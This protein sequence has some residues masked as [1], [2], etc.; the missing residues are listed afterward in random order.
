MEP[1]CK[2]FEKLGAYMQG[3]WKLRGLSAILQNARFK[4]QINKVN[5]HLNKFWNNVKDLHAILK[6]AG[7]EMQFCKVKSWKKGFCELN[8]GPMYNF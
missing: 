7:V 3:F 2:G 1:K 8:R 4:I 5:M 6:H